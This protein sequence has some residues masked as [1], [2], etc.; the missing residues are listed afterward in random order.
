MKCKR[1]HFKERSVLRISP[2]KRAIHLLYKLDSKT[3]QM[4]YKENHILIKEAP[5]QYCAKSEQIM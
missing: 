5:E 4:L 2:N 1:L 3:N